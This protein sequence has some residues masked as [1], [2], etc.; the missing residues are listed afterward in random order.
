MVFE[1]AVCNLRVRAGDTS[2]PKPGAPSLPSGH[3]S[4]FGRS[5]RAQTS[6]AAITPP[7]RLCACYLGI[8]VIGGS[9][10]MPPMHY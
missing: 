2:T 7:R 8:A 9:E 6:G 1:I 10:T 4:E 5:P 3:A